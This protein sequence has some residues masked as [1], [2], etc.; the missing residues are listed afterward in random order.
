[1]REF[2]KRWRGPA[3]AVWQIR[4]NSANVATKSMKTETAVLFEQALKIQGRKNTPRH[5]VISVPRYRYPTLEQIE[6]K[7]DATE[8]VEIWTP[9][10]GGFS[11][12]VPHPGTGEMVKIAAKHWV[13]GLYVPERSARYV[14]ANNFLAHMLMEPG[15]FVMKNAAELGIVLK[16]WRFWMWYQGAQIK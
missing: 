16:P 11:N 6:G 12:Q 2:L 1:M 14:L 10:R 4:C 5:K 13:F 7:T 8:I 3:S 15:A 9:M